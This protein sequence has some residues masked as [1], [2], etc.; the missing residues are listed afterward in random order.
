MTAEA[1]TTVGGVAG[2]LDLQARLADLGQLFPQFPGVL[3][4]TGRAVPS[5]DGYQIDLIAK[6]PGAINASVRGRMAGDF[7]SADL[8]IAGTAT[9]ALANK[10][11][12][13]RSLS[14]PV[15][16]DLRLLGPL[17]LAS[18]NGPVTISGG[19]LADPAQN[20]A[21]QDISGSAQLAG[22]Q[23]QVAGRAAV[24]TGGQIVFSGSVGLDAPYM[25]DMSVT[26]QSVVLRDPDLY[27]TVV[28]GALTFKGPSRGGALIA[29]SV[30]L[31]RT[32]LRIPS[33]GLGADGDL[34]GLEHVHEPADVRATRL[35]AGLL[36]AA[37]AGGSG[38]AGY[39]LNL[40][41]SAPNQ[42]FIRGRGLDGELGGSLTL[43]GT[44]DAIAP[45]GAFNL[46]RGRLDI[47]GRRL[48]LSEALLQLQG[49]LVPYVR[50]LASVESDGI[51]ASV[52]IEGPANDP[53]VT[54]TSSPDLPQEEVIARLLFDRGLENLTAF[55][56][57]QLAGAVA[58]LAGRGGEGVIGNLRRKAGLDNLDVKTDAVG[59]TA[60]TLGKY[61]S[62]KV[63]TEVTVDQ[64][65]KSA[66]SLNL[67]IASHITLKGH[68]DS[69]G[70]TG[71][72][73]FLQKDY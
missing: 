43:R 17:S 46:I 11:A 54:F 64:G 34:P 21:V 10:L 31:G 25:A 62:D 1:G 29:G 2:Q 68:V 12:A 3:T 70:Q 15:R 16:F 4:A 28:N 60:V 39:A 61:L 53:L 32:E 30:S 49:A 45:T 35:R 20:F 58:T 14:G 22:G 18:L 48:D 56:A 41:I 55:Q 24:S 7:A 13:P 33:T 23:A 44:T 26:L 63:Y 42:V 5:G 65:G 36:A 50:I 67:D 40:Q 38:G 27:T 6:G 72:G 8:A 19:R 52:L 69:D 51:T 71:I 47:L 57:I 9:A 59:N 66:I 37:G 73:V